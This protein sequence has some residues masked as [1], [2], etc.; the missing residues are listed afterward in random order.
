MGAGPG[1]H[2]RDPVRDGRAPRARLGDPRHG[3]HGLRLR[4][5]SPRTWSSR[6]S[7]SARCCAS[8]TASRQGADDDFTVR[9]LNEM[10]VA[11]ES[12]SRVMAMLLLCVASISLLVGGIGIMNILLVSVTE[13]TREIGIRM[14]VG[15]RR[16]HILLQFLVE[17]VV[18]SGAGGVIGVVLGVA[19]AWRHFDVCRLADADLGRRGRGRAPVLGDGRRLL[20]LLAGAPRRRSRSDRGASLRVGGRTAGRQADRSRRSRGERRDAGRTLQRGVSREDGRAAAAALEPRRSPCSSSTCCG[21][22]ACC[23]GSSTCASIRAWPRIPSISTTCP[24]RTV[25]SARSPGPR[26]PRRAVFALAARAWR[27]SLVVGA[28]VASHWLLDWVVHRPDL[29]LWG[30]SAKH[31]LALW[32]FPVVALALELAAADR[33]RRRRGCARAR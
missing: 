4:R 20:R 3:G 13:R 12:A 7:R 21:P 2:G 31:G 9:N 29:L 10:A 24:T 17:A 22:S 14:A 28:A 1:R 16:Q 30:G 19:A 11:Q 6:P 18:L 33:E 25:W 15:A 5:A 8:A 26:S 27:A 32:N 23:S